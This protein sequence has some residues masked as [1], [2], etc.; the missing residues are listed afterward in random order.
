MKNNPVQQKVAGRKALC[1]FLRSLHTYCA[2]CTYLW[3]RRS[4]CDR[5]YP[6]RNLEMREKMKFTWF[7]RPPKFGKRMAMMILGIGMQGFGLSLLIR[8]NFGTDPCSVLTQGV[9]AH[10]PLTF[11]T[12]QLLCHLVTFL[13]VIRY[14]MSR[15]GFATIGNMVFMGYI[16]D[17][18]G[19]L[20][21]NLAPESFFEGLPVR[22]CLLV[23]A[24]CIFIL[25]ASAYMTSGLGASPYDSL[26]FI[27]SQRMK[28]VSFKIIRMLWDF[29]FMAVGGILGGD[30]GIVT[31]AMAFFLGPVI[32]WMG[33]KQ[34]GW[35]K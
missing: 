2:L 3:K 17:F 30:A 10:V 31:V 24:L 27:I 22:L 19:M 6:K 5:I 23:P 12:A 15:I 25:G 16:A 29:A 26:P 21:D 20:W 9:I 13:F 1:H 14:D 33:K 8:I 28:K 11:G 35:L 32:S 4:F 34:E 18:F 7:A